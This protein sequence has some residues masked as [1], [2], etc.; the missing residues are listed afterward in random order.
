M[1]GVPRLR[2]RIRISRAVSM[3]EIPGIATSSRISAKSCSSSLASAS[4][5]ELANTSLRPSGPSAASIAV[6]FAG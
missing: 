6:R 5:P 1:M 2:S 3:P 4:V